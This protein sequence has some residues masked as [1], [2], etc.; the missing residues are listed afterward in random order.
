MEMQNT[1]NY[2]AD[3]ADIL[4]LG[5][6]AGGKINGI[7]YFNAFTS[8]DYLTDNSFTAEKTK[9]FRWQ[10]DKSALAEKLRFCRKTAMPEA[11][12]KQVFENDLA[13]SDYLFENALIMKEDDTV[14]LTQTGKYCKHRRSAVKKLILPEFEKPKENMLA[15]FIPK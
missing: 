13:I 10:A 1:W 4:A 8:E 2:Q 6:G 15:E 5:P 12:F 11:E 14:K 7:Q 9:I 3:D